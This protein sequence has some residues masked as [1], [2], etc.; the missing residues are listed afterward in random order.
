MTYLLDTSILIELKEENNK[1]VEKIAELISIDLAPPAISFMNYFEFIQGLQ[2]KSEK[3]KKTGLEFI[4]KFQF[5]ELTKKSAQ[6][7][8]DLKYN[9]EKIGKVFSLSDLIIASQAIENSMTLITSDKHF[10]E[11]EELNKII[12]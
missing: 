1:I 2:K 6:I 12:I 7:L 5:L 4:E 8:S 10:E 11:I 9:Y 3:H